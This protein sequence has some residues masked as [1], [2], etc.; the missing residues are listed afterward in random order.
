MTFAVVGDRVTT[1]RTRRAD[2]TFVTGDWVLPAVAYAAALA[3]L[4][5]NAA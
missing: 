5:K 2:H 3:G 4:G 1:M